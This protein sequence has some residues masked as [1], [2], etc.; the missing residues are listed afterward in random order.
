[1]KKVIDFEKIALRIEVS[2]RGGGIEISLKSLGFDGKMTAYQNYLGGG[3]LGKVCNDC[4]VENWQ[5]NKK[6]C[7]IANQL[8]EYYHNLSN[9]E[10]GW[11]SLS[12]TQNQS[13]PVS[14]C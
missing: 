8:K 14:S 12:Y 6:L 5:N 3:L 2:G 4:T 9:P 11:E 10:A 1:M 7:K 13:M